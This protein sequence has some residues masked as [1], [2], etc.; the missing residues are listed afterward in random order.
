MDEA[1]PQDGYAPPGVSIRNGP[2]LEDKME[3]EQ[4]A[5]NGVAKRKARNST[6]KAVKYNDDESEEHDKDIPLVCN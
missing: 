1:I 6:G 2:I 3:V 4:S 5:T